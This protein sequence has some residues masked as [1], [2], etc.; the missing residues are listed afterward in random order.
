MKT[1]LTCIVGGNNLFREGLKSLLARTEYRV[2]ASC[3][4][5]ADLGTA[6]SL[7]DAK[8]FMMG[9]N[10]SDDVETAALRAVRARHPHSRIFVVTTTPS[11]S[12]FAKCLA[13]GMDAYLLADA[14][15]EVLL[16]SLRLVLHG[17]QVFPSMLVTGALAD[18]LERA[19]QDHAAVD[20]DRRLSAR[21]REILTLLVEGASNKAIGIRLNIEDSTVKVHLRRILRKIP[22]ANRTQAAVWAASKGLGTPAAV[23]GNGLAELGKTGSPSIGFHNSLWK[24]GPM[25]R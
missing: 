2:I 11:R 22:A 13:A 1:V 19:Q 4:Q 20:K 8:L 17:V 16:E 25:S 18:D 14:P 24:S 6:A 12:H 5:L 9:S 15:R 10:L 3:E 21:E 7:P 23:T